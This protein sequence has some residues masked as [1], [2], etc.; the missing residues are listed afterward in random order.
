MV[1]PRIP[2]TELDVRALSHAQWITVRDIGFGG[3]LP[4][5]AMDCSYRGRSTVRNVCA[6]ELALTTGMRLSEWSTLLDCEI[7]H[8]LHG[9]SIALQAC[10][11]N[12]RSR[13]VYIPASTIAHRST[14]TGTPN[15][16][17]SFRKSQASLRSKLA[18]LAVVTEIDHSAGKLLY[19]MGSENKRTQSQ[20]FRSSYVVDLSGSMTPASSNRSPSSSARAA[21]HRHSDD[22]TNTSPRRTNDSQGLEN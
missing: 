1:S 13:R 16:W 12:E 18:S 4:N 11:K 3:Q 2:K 17:R 10:A 8:D 7:A 19:R 21:N 9:V 14:S 15:A 5:G 20:Q 6:V 22:G